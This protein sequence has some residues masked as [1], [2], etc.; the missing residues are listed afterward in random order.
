MLLMGTLVVIN[1]FAQ[2]LP[3]VYDVENTGVGFPKPVL[4][5]FSE[6]PVIKPLTDPFEWSDRS[7]RSTNFDDW[8]HRRAEIGEEI[9]HYEIGDKPDRPDTLS[10]TLIND[11]LK[12]TIVKNGQTLVLTSKIIYPA[13]EGPFPAVIGIGFGGG[14]GSLP[15]SIFSSR[16]IAQIPFNFS[17]VM[18]HQQVR[19]KE[20]INK[21]YPELIHMGAYAAWSWGV[22]RLIDGLELVKDSSKIDLQHLAVTGCSFAGKMAL[23]AGAFDERIALTIA[24]ESGGGG[25]A[26]WRVSQSLKVSVETLSATNGNWF[27]QSMFQFGGNV[28]KLPHDHHELMAM[29]APRALLVLGNSSMI[30]LAEES[31]Y[32]SSRAAHEV[33]KNFGI[34]DRFGFSIVGGHDHCALPASQFPEVEAFVDKFLLGITTANTNVTISPYETVDYQRWYK[35]WGTDNPEFG[36]REGENIW[37]EAECAGKGKSWIYKSSTVTSN[38]SYVVVNTSFNSPTTPPE[39]TESSIIFPFSIAKDSTF[40]VF[41]RIH[42]PTSNDD[43]FW[44]KIDNG[45]FVKV[46]GFTSSSWIWKNLISQELKAGD[47]TFTIA[48]CEDGAKLDKICIS[49]NFFLPF[50]KGEPAQN[51]CIPGTT[52][53]NS[54]ESNN[55]YSLDNYPNPFN[56]NTTIS[57]EVPEDTY[58]SLKVYNV[59]GSEIAELAGKKYTQGKYTVDFNAD[60]LLAG[61]YFYE[62]NTSN[63]SMS[64]KMVLQK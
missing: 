36:T 10:A 24:Q 42:G 26:A 15:P 30:W 46:N 3:L 22:S 53:V 50:D 48:Y 35:W 38:N 62:M 1:S 64:K 6:L 20:P 16:N 56:S 43:A 60:K 45:K 9:Q 40:H 13:G 27:L 5:A 21:L 39:D 54:L 19:G 11:T 58:I 14:S 52:E 2:E 23:F 31:G 57:F 4:P 7:G 47:H 41:A 33:W 51:I 63:F 49:D 17:Q 37:L 12:V 59:Y 32:V 61:V 28:S 18:A 55:L 34:G 25:A 8:A 29:I 44:I